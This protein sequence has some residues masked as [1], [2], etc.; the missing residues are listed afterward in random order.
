MLEI[1]ILYKLWH[2]IGHKARAKGYPPR[3]YQLMLLLFWFGGEFCTLFLATFFFVLAFGRVLDLNT[4]FAL[5]YFPALGTAIFGVWRL[6]KLVN[7][8]PDMTAPA[9]AAV[10]T[11]AAEVNQPAAA[12]APLP[13]VPPGAISAEPMNMPP[14]P[15]EPPPAPKPAPAPSAT[16]TKKDEADKDTFRELIETVVFVVVL[17]LMLKTFLAEAFVIPTGSMANTLLGYHYK[18]ICEDCR[19]PNLINASAE[20]EPQNN[21]AVRITGYKCTNCGHINTIPDR[22]GGRP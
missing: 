15:L 7:D 9:Q 12:A 19:Y 2:R 20:A 8:L 5:A 1:I 17:V 14:I 4:A 3:K 22:R 10:A 18:E 11:S 13:A 6:F 16:A 21:R